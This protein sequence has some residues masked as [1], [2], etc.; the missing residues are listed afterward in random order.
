MPAKPANAKPGQSTIVEDAPKPDAIDNDGGVHDD[1][2]VDEITA[3]LEQQAIRIENQADQI[4]GLETR[5]AALERGYAGL[6]R[7]AEKGPAKPTMTQ[8]EAQKQ[9]NVS[10]KSVLSVDGWVAPKAG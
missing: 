1:S 10:G 3:L 5:L 6:S 9:A 7:S 4:D 2:E 8:A